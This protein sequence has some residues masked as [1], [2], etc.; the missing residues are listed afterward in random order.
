MGEKN[1]NYRPELD[2]SE[3]FGWKKV[4]EETRPTEDEQQRWSLIS[5]VVAVALGIMVL[6]IG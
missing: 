6:I 4:S 3:D 2:R 5:I 1:M